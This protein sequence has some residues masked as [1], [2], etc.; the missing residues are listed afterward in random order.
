MTATPEQVLAVTMHDRAAVQESLNSSIAAVVVPVALPT[1]TELREAGTSNLTLG[2][3]PTE[4]NIAPETVFVQQ[5]ASLKRPAPSCE[6]NLTRLIG[7]SDCVTI[8]LCAG[9]ATLSAALKARGFQVV[10]V[11]HGSN[12]HR[13]HVACVQIDLTSDYAMCLIEDLLV[14]GQVKYC[15]LA[16]PCGT[17]TKARE[18]RVPQ[19]LQARGS[20]DPLPLR[21]AAFPRGLETLSGV[22]LNKVL[23]AN[24]IYDLAAKVIY[25]C[26]ELGIMVSCENPINSYMWQIV[27]FPALLTD[28]RLSANSWDGCMH[29]GNRDKTS[30]WLATK[31]LFDD[32]A[33]RCDGQHVHKPWSIDLQQGKWTF[34][35]AEEAEYTSLLCQRL[36]DKVEQHVITQGVIPQPV[37]MSQSGLSAMQ[38]KLKSRAEVGKQPRGRRLPPLISEYL[39]V[40]ETAET[41]AD[42][43]HKVLRRFMKVGEVG[44]Q[45]TEHSIVGVLRDPIAFMEQA[46]VTGHPMDAASSVPDITK[47]ALFRIFTTEPSNLAQQRMATIK[48]L[49]ARRNELMHKEREL[50]DSMPPHLRVILKGKQLLLLKELLIETNF[51][52]SALVDDIV[53]GFDVVGKASVSNELHKRIQIA[54]ITP[55]ELRLRSALSRRAILSKHKGRLSTTLDQKVWDD[56]LEEVEKGWIKGPMCARDIDVLHPKGWCAIHRFGL[57]QKDKVRIIDDC[58]EPNINEAFT[59]VEKLD[60]MDVDSLAAIYRLIFT[61]IN[62]QNVITI[63]LSTGEVL[64]SKVHK[65]FRGSRF[66]AMS[67]RLLDLKSAY[68]QLGTSL[69]TL[70]ASILFA[71]NPATGDIAFFESSALMFGA[72]ASVYSFNRCSRAL[73]HVATILLNFVL[74]VFYDDFPGT[75]PVATAASARASLE[76]FMS[77]LGWQ[78]ATS[79]H[80]S[81]PYQSVFSPLGVTFDLSR[82]C[83]G[84]I[85]I[86]NK[87]ER[88]LDL[89]ASIDG[90]LSR[91]DHYQGELQSLHSKMLFAMAQVCGRAAVPAVRILS[92]HMNQGGRVKDN[93]CLC[94][95]LVFLKDML[96]TAKPRII[97][98]QDDVRP[99]V[100]LTDAAAE[101]DIVTFGTFLVD[102]ATGHRLV[103]G[104]DIPPKL[105]VWWRAHVGEQIIGQAELFPIIITRAFFGKSWVNR[106]LIFYV[107]NDSA[108]DAMVKS[109]SPSLAS[110]N[111]I[112]A[113]SREES[114]SPSYPWFARVPSASNVSDWPTRGKLLDAAS[115]GK[116]SVLALEWT[117]TLLNSFMMEH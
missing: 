17:A 73:W 28:V 25:R 106:R 103:A 70:W 75:E 78:Y 71:V 74:T 55:E 57:E 104:G 21:S 6:Q 2:T 20:P 79:E 59:S 42:P 44:S 31:G 4:I 108:R 3:M 9:S 34:A 91:S 84:T 50:H 117:E 14:S 66:P 93:R 102:T 94:K 37:S 62:E 72:T 49:Q 114:C 29:G 41:P 98:Y 52:D 80:K 63:T 77:V 54:T 105:V 99:I 23:Q 95:A 116:A 85:E 97:S 7:V 68:K 58:K 15:H 13:Q 100:I 38:R 24:K 32:L 101:G 30:L 33:L 51:G 53:K 27:P 96:T 90:L 48:R 92:N 69:D 5:A 19:W 109:Y 26:L 40:F 111:L 46:I 47:N 112:Y 110:Q 86:K 43:L 10:P 36:A 22:A 56:C 39:D 83:E 89:V 107:D 1:T 87:S 88:I 60:L 8:E 11:D 61:S 12:R 113:F 18:R 16:P 76:A 115:Q 65:S 81:L 67:G 45:P 82:M 35:T 64:K